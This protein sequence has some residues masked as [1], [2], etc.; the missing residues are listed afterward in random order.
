MS[1][2]VLG[3]R[4]HLHKGYHASFLSHPPRGFSYG[5]ASPLIRFES[6]RRR[7]FDPYVHFSV[8]EAHE[9]AG[10]YDRIHSAHYPVH[11]AG[12]PWLVDTD[13]LLV[14][15]FAGTAGYSP[16]FDEWSAS[17]EAEPLIA[18]RAHRMLA[19]YLAPDCVAILFHT[20]AQIDAARR[21]AAALG[22]AFEARAAALW[23]KAIVCPP[24]L[25]TSWPWSDLSAQK[26]PQQ[27]R[28]VF[29]ARDYESKGGD[30]ALALFSSL[31]RRK[32]VDLCYVGP[33]P[34]AAARRF[35]GTLGRVRHWPSLPRDA[36]LELFRRSHVLLML[37]K[38]ETLGITL[39]EAMACGMA[40]VAGTGPGLESAAEVV[41]HGRGGLL[42][43][44]R[45]L[46][47]G[48]CLADVREASI[49]LLDD[50]RLLERI[51][52]FNARR[53]P[54]SLRERNRILREVLRRAPGAGPLSR[55]APPEE[56]RRVHV[57]TEDHLRRL[58]TAFWRRHYPDGKYL[59][60]IRFPPRGSGP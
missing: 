57:F 39:V 3:A 10:T 59:F 28:F 53:G 12:C 48:L 44:K 26:P 46:D 51:M 49:R 47:E 21:G 55:I 56:G 38:R 20:R 27:V 54:S 19:R 30:T 36:L 41:E 1:R 17:R 33:I 29:A 14:H 22:A 4:S 58:R 32:D 60:W 23:K 16:R 15:I 52:R 5:T 50:R 6:A 43:P 24:V 2:V 13:C 11:R 34:D 9:Y 7:G 42:V 18:E 25:G 37:S 31:S 8:D 40:I 35:R 45:S